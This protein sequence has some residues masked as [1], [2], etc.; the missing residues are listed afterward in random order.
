MVDLK[1][2]IKD[3]FL[4]EEE[5]CDYNVEKKIKEVWAVELD[6]FAEFDRVCKKYNIPYFADGGTIL[7]TI[8]H[9][10][11]IPWDDDIDLAMRRDDYD[12][13]CNHAD[14]FEFPYF[15]QTNYTDPGSLIGHAQ[16]R[17]SLTTGALEYETGRWI[18][19]GIFID[20]FPI[21]NVPDDEKEF[22]IQKKRIINY[23]KK[24]IR[25]GRNVFITDNENKIK[26][27]IKKALLKLG[28]GKIARK[29]ENH[30]Y[31]KMEIECQKYN[32]TE[33][34]NCSLL[35]FQC[36]WKRLIRENQD[37]KSVV[38]MPFEFV[39]LPIPVGYDKVLT[40]LYG[41][42]NKIIMNSSAHGGII[43]DTDI[44]YEEYLKQKYNN[45]YY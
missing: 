4:E 40:N 21:D 42:Y 23:K 31:S 6:L 32:N 37:Y 25:Y 15:L 35:S 16:L 38:M 13:L 45:K 33:T 39:E 10:G 14:D 26:N 9:K 27:A 43:F 36:D 12:K 8:R 22:E 29:L 44:P 19:Q 18:N 7:G 20:I 17:N 28:F 5:R 34:R 3:A 30:Y 11:F 24:A 1:I 41:D 2:N